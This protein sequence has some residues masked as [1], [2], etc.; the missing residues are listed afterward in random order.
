M[1]S[2]LQRCIFEDA[3]VAKFI[4]KRATDA[5]FLDLLVFQT[6]NLVLIK[7]LYQEVN[8]KPLE[9]YSRTSHDTEILRPNFVEG[10][11][12]HSIISGAQPK[13][14]NLI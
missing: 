11:E 2:S 5:D 1:N 8:N 4:I 14:N 3:S 6:C 13:G 7:E 12:P 10:C 9:V